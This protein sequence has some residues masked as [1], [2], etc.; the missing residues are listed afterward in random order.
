MKKTPKERMLSKLKKISKEKKYLKYP[1]ILAMIAVIF[2][3]DVLEYFSKNGKRYMSITVVMFMFILSSSF[4]FPATGTTNQVGPGSDSVTT[5]IYEEPVAN[6]YDFDNTEVVTTD[7]NSVID[8]D[9]VLEEDDVLDEYENEDISEIDNLDVFTVDEILE[10]NNVETEDTTDGNKKTVSYSEL[11]DDEIVADI[12]D[13]T[14]FSKD[15]WQL[16]L[17][18]KQHPVPDD[19]EFTLGT[20]KGSMMCDERIVEDLL[21]ML[22]GAKEDSVNLV[23]CS[24]YRDMHRQ[25]VLFNRKIDIYMSRGNSYMEAYS[26]A[27]QTVTVPGASEHQIGLAFDIICDDYSALNAGFGET[28]AGKW[29][30]KHCCE[31]GF[32]LRYPEGKQYIT[33]IEYEPWHFR[34]VGVE[35]ATVIMKEGITLEEFIDDL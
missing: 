23:I 18:N 26:L 5:V 28:D 14:E 1:V 21:N 30:A 35:A 11:T 13:N 9:D 32:I 24:P 19:Y 25:E 4:S 15:D 31:Y 12:L 10:E 17:I 3:F 27:S 8:D 2:I 7:N 22:Q 29:L 20:I 34:Y 33:S 16:V 6:N